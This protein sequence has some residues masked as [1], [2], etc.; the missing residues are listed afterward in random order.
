[1]KNFERF[2]FGQSINDFISEKGLVKPTDIQSLVFPLLMKKTSVCALGKTGS[3]KTFAFALP[4]L[5]W[6]K[7]DELERGRMPGPKAIVLAPTKELALQLIKSLKSVSHHV[8][9]QIGSYLGDA[10]SKGHIKQNMPDVIVSVPGALLRGMRDKIIPGESVRWL[11]L[12]EGDELLKGPFRADIAGIFD[13]LT[14]PELTVG[15]FSAS[16]SEAERGKMRELFSRIKLSEVDDGSANTIHVKIET[17]NI[18]MLDK[19][20]PELLMHF[21]KRQGQGKGIVFVNKKDSLAPLETGLR[22]RM[23]SKV[24]Y[25]ISGDLDYRGRKKVMQAFSKDPTGLLIATDVV[26]RG[27]HITDLAWIL[28]YDLPFESAYYI[29]RCGRVGR[30]GTL[31]RVYNF[32]TFKD[33]PLIQKINDSIAKQT[34]LKLDV[35]KTKKIKDTREKPHQ[36]ARAGKK[37]PVQVVKKKVTRTVVKRKPGFSRRKKSK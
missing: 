36:T 27:M 7:S 28:N 29:H 24:F 33:M 13:S 6:I 21:L 5:H 4:M 12:D 31:G 10:K 2:N 14:F 32:I 23:P 15:L 34:A 35:L 20:K 11:I 1:M 30:E 16:L 18:E 26:A 8:K 9:L 22:E 19:E 25:T 37:A 17:Y 3:G